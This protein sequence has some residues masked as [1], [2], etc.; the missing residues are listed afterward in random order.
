[1]T[2]KIRR[3][4]LALFDIVVI[5]IAVIFA[6]A[7]K[8]DFVIPKEQWTFYLSVAILLSGG[9]LVVFHMFSLYDSLWEYASIEELMKIIVA[10]MLS[11]VFGLIYI[12]TQGNIFPATCF[13]T[14]MMFE[15]AGIISIRFSYRIFRRLKNK[16]SVTSQDVH[17]SGSDCGNDSKRNVRETRHTWKT[18]WL[19]R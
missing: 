17:R 10:V 19:H 3:Y 16:R 9:K 18:S 8:Y 13:V 1:M 5:N 6:L 4:Y 7:L 2:K 15:M 14:M 11:S 12:F